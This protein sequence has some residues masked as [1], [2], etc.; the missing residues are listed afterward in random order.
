MFIVAAVYL[1][2]YFCRKKLRYRSVVS[3]VH[4]GKIFTGFAGFY[5]VASFKS[6]AYQL[7][8]FYK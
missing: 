8:S 3:I 7:D 1:S 6:S 4:P 2:T 5:I